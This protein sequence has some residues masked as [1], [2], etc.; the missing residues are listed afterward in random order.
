MD[1]FKQKERILYGFKIQSF[2]NAYRH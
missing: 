1:Q 2:L